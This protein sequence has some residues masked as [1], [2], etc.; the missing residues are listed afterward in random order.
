MAGGYL[1]VHYSRI[2]FYKPPLFCQGVVA[3]E[4]NGSETLPEWSSMSVAEASDA[5]GLLASI[6]DFD[7][8]ALWNIPV[9]P[10]IPCRLTRKISGDRQLSPQA[11]GSACSYQ[12]RC[13]PTPDREG[14]PVPTPL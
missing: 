7:N 4:G 1:R 3:T 11:K 12:I 9:I 5:P 6:M 8:Q 13:S 2:W 10:N 14:L